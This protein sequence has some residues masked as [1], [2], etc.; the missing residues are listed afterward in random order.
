MINNRKARV[1]V[2]EAILRR[3]IRR[4]MTTLPKLPH[5]HDAIPLVRQAALSIGRQIHVEAEKIVSESPDLSITLLDGA[6]K[7]VA[8]FDYVA[9]AFSMPGTFELARKVTADLQERIEEILRRVIAERYGDVDPETFGKD[10]LHKVWPDRE[11]YFYKDDLLLI[12][13]KPRWDEITFEI[14]RGPKHGD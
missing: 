10:S 12:V 9:R 6:G 1:I 5:T 8:E 13:H 7:P 4:A 11:E 2:F 3:N 14:H